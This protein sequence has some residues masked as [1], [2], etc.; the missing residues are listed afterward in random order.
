MISKAARRYASA[1]LQTVLELDKLE[2]AKKDMELIHSVIANSRDLQLF[3]KSPIV[4]SDKK[5]SA[6]TEIFESQVGDEAMHLITLLVK[7]K[8]EALLQP[9]SK[10][11]LNLYNI[12]KNIIEVDV[13]TAYNLTKN[14][15]KTLLQSLEKRTGKNV[16]MD[17]RVDASILGGVVIKIDDTVIDDS[18]KHKIS[19]LKNQFAANAVS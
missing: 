5:M 8:R 19:Q 16:K 14:Q 12:E 6:L 7:K 4:R 13:K 9:I 1:Y 10:G 2:D 11:V 3:L 15:E 17:L 18:V